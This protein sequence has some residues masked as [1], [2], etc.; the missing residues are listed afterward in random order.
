[1]QAAGPTQKMRV[2][3]AGARKR[4]G[5]D[6]GCGMQ[7][8]SQVTASGIWGSWLRG[9]GG[10]GFRG[11]TSRSFPAT[12][13][14][15][16]FGFRGVWVSGFLGF[17]DGNGRVGMRIACI[18]ARSHHAGVE[19]DVAVNFAQ[20]LHRRIHALGHIADKRL[21]LTTSGRTEPNPSQSCVAAI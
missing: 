12:F 3:D 5:S 4:A 8:S 15:W 18:G 7:G 20:L 2:A 16:V 19:N 9:F 6:A 17:W 10:S 11:A 1:M 14:F 13:G 21:H